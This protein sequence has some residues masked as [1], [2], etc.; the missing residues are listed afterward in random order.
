MKTINDI[1]FDRLL[2]SQANHSILIL[3]QTDGHLALFIKLTNASS[4]KF[5]E[6]YNNIA[7]C[8]DH[9]QGNHKKTF[10]LFIYSENF[11]TW[12]NNDYDIPKNLHEIIL[13]Y[14]HSRN[15]EYIQHWTNHYSQVKNIIAHGELECELLLYG[16]KY[17]RELR[18]DYQDNQR[19]LGLLVEDYKNLCSALKN[20]FTAKLNKST[21]LV[22][23]T[24]VKDGS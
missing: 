24:S 20:C 6:S 22:T 13:F 18:L 15:K 10:T 11:R 16:I 19:I 12:L 21:D 3:Y 7:D 8:R 14:P 9:I 23:R 5:I 1:P 17:I 2:Y 4:M